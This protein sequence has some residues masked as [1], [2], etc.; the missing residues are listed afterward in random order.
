MEKQLAD[1]LEISPDDILELKQ[2]GDVVNVITVAMAKFVVPMEALAALPSTGSGGAGDGDGEAAP[3]D[4][5]V[6]DGIGE[7][8]AKKLKEKAGISTFAGL[9]A[10]DSEETAVSCTLPLTK[11]REWQAEA[12]VLAR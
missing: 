10:A 3:D 4:L 6:I 7:S 9:V 11:L 12:A 8:T 1:Y 2:R 5:T